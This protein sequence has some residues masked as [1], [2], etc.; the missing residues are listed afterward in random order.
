MKDSYIACQPP[1]RAFVGLLLC[2]AITEFIVALIASIFTCIFTCCGGNNCCDGSQQG[3]ELYIYRNCPE[4]RVFSLK[5]LVK[6]FKSLLVS[7]CLIS[8]IVLF[9]HSNISHSVKNL[10]SY[11]IENLTS[12]NVVWTCKTFYG[13]ALISH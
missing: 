6:F 7:C 5:K 3:N 12:S 13:S 8:Q 2:L 1:G 9:F 4:K 10:I 11:R